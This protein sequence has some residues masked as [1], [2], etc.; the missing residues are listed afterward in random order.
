MQPLMN[1][2]CKQQLMKGKNYHNAM[3]NK[4]SKLSKC[5]QCITLDTHTQHIYTLRFL[6]SLPVKET[7]KT[8]RS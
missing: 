6:I 2:I 5:T 1:S 4:K 3:L 7:D 8:E